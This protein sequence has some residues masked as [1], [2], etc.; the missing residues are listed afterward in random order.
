MKIL[1][2]KK[3]EEEEERRK[4]QIIQNSD[5]LH[6]EKKSTWGKKFESDPE[7]GPAETDTKSGESRQLDVKYEQRVEFFFRNLQK[8][9]EQNSMHSISFISL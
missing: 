4:E 2:C 7:M 6:G 8:E 5:Y 3:G 9:R 1:Y